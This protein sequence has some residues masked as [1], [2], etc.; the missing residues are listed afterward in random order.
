MITYVH[1]LDNP[2]MIQLLYFLRLKDIYVLTQVSK[3]NQALSIHHFIINELLLQIQNIFT[4]YERYYSIPFFTTR[5]THL[6][7]LKIDFINQNFYIFTNKHYIVHIP[8]QGMYISC[9]YTIHHRNLVKI[10]KFYTTLVYRYYEQSILRDAL[11]TNR[12]RL[13]DVMY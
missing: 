4:Y 2:N 5:R 3:N 12:L 10:F 13:M 8:I 1:F 11:Q 7:H 9:M 6:Q